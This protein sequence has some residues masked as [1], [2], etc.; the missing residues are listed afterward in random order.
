MEVTVPNSW[1]PL[2]KVRAGEN[3][4]EE[5]EAAVAAAIIRHYAALRGGPRVT[6]VIITGW[7]VDE[8]HPDRILLRGY[9]R[10]V[11]SPHF[12]VDPLNIYI[13]G[14]RVTKFDETLLTLKFDP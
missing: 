5:V 11:S 7:A 13:P 8:V 2:F 14:T 9:P 3:T 1:R 4:S 12:A 6:D 10:M